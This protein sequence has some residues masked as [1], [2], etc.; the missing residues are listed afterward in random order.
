MAGQFQAIGDAAKTLLSGKRNIQEQDG[1]LE[2]TIPFLHPFAAHHDT[3]NIF[4]NRAI[5]RVNRMRT[6]AHGQ[7]GTEWELPARSEHDA[8]LADDQ[9][10]VVSETTIDPVVEINRET[11]ALDIT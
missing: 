6:N 4:A 2:K 10:T 11:R 8:S 5:A 1:R 3:V 9:I 7:L